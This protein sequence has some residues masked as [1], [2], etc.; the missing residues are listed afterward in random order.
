MYLDPKLEQQLQSEQDKTKTVDIVITCDEFSS[1]V[2]A[3][4]D[5]AG[6]HV[7]GDEL[8]DQGILSGSISLADLE[9]LRDTKGLE[10]IELDSTQYAL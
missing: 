10:S 6:F 4:I 8:A 1:E 9:K 2:R 3:E 5:R 7:T